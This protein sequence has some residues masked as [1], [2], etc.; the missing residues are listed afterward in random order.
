MK[1]SNPK[2]LSHFEIDFKNRIFFS[3]FLPKFGILLM[4]ATE[5]LKKNW[6]IITLGLLFGW[7]KMTFAK[8]TLNL[9]SKSWKNYP[10]EE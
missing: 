10:I 9:R 7:L 4:G 3:D 5:L 2:F 1:N 8:E 6:I